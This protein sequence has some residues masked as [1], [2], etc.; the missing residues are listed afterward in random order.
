MWIL[1]EGRRLFPPGFPQFD[2]YGV[3]N[4]EKYFAKYR[5]TVLTRV[6]EWRLFLGMMRMIIRIAYSL[7]NNI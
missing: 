5:E 4:Y 2:F 7:Q 1:W 6:S 3:I